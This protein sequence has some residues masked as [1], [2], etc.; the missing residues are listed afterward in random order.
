MG[1]IR[2][3]LHDQCIPSLV[4]KMKRQIQIT[5]PVEHM[6]RRLG[7]RKSQLDGNMKSR[8]TKNKKTAPTL[9]NRLLIEQCMSAC[10]V[11][12]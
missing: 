10:N 8:N 12:L 9:R 11:P 3:M 6:M 1:E 4:R 5:L 7:A 2:K